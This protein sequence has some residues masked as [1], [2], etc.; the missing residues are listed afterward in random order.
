MAR[1]RSIPAARPVA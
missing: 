1:T